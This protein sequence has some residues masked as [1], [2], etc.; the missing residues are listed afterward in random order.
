MARDDLERLEEVAPGARTLIKSAIA[1]LT[2]HP[3]VGRGVEDGLREL[4]ISRGKSGYVALY[5]FEGM[6]DQVVIHALRHQR[7]AGH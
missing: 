3:L 7:E 5:D 4:V 6:L 2:D 1:I